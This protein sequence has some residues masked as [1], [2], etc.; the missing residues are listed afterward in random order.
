MLVKTNIPTRANQ[1]EKSNSFY[2][3]STQPFF[4]PAIQPKL[5]FGEFDDNYEREANRVADVVMR[6]PD[7]QM[8]PVEE[9][10]KKL[11]MQAVGEKEKLRM[12]PSDLY[13][14]IQPPQRNAKT[15]SQASFPA[16]AN[17]TGIRIQKEEEPNPP[18]MSVRGDAVRQSP[19][20]GVD[21]R[22][23]KLEWELIFKGDM[24]STS[25]REGGISVQLGR[26]VI[27]TAKFHPAPTSS[28]PRITFVQ[29]VLATTGGVQ[30]TGHLLYTSDAQGR[31]LDVN[32]GATEPYYGAAGIPE[33]SGAGLQG[34]VGQQIGGGSSQATA[35]HGDA[36]YYHRVPPGK[37]VERQFETAVICVE[38]G[39]TYGS[40]TWGYR[41]HSNGTI[42]LQGA[43]RSDI[44]TG[45]ASSTLENVHQAFY[46]GAFQ[47]SL[48]GFRRGS[49]TLT[50]SHKQQLDTIPTANLRRIVL[51]GANDNSGGPES[52]AALSLERARKVK[53]YLVRHRNIAA[54]LIKVEGHGVA[55]RYANRQGQQEPRNRRVD[56]RYERGTEQGSIQTPGSPA[57]TTASPS[58][59]RRIR[60]QNPWFTAS[61]T[62][63]LIVQLDS[64]DSV[65]MPQWVELL[66]MLQAMQRWRATD[67]T[68]PDIRDTHRDALS[69]IRRK[70]RTG[71]IP[72]QEPQF[73]PRVLEPPDF[74]D[75]IREES[76]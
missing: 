43:Q 27:F 1:R 65:R 20:E 42:E 19:D 45:G 28:C 48:Q 2:R 69:R 21:I 36:P 38:S 50:R 12:Q 56:I 67:P 16:I 25:S 6:M 76:L 30:D 22:H 47:L 3:E 51:V 49:S 61:E 15:R 71:R 68:V 73:R 4:K 31:S 59:M 17:R 66:E 57:S 39:E 7:P 23:G 58:E 24:L 54:N 8:Q 74:I 40:I 52:R 29:S 14:I 37:L 55:A 70:L 13:S 63:R 62:V 41:K 26:D 18:E 44:H 46:Q 34:D 33:S 10:E 75:R 64:A 9:E 32:H 53:Q 11:Q 60:G 72:R 35:T 5:K